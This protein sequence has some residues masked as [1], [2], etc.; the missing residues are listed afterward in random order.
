[1]NDLPE[2]QFVGELQRLELKPGDR[3]VLHCDRPLPAVVAEHL[4]R[5]WRRFVGDRADEF[6]LLV[7]EP[8]MRLGVIGAASTTTLHDQ[9]VAATEIRGTPV[10]ALRKAQP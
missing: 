5:G 2:I 9:I 4:E 10:S 8:G 7:L 1:M 6:P 3:F